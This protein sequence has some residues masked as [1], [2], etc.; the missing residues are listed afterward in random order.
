MFNRLF[1]PWKRASPTEETQP[2]ASDHPAGGQCDGK[3]YDKWVSDM[4]WQDIETADQSTLQNNSNSEVQSTSEVE[5]TTEMID[6]A[7]YNVQEA[8]S[9]ASEAPV[10]PFASDPGSSSPQPEPMEDVRGDQDPKEGPGVFSTFLQAPRPKTSST[11]KTKNLPSRIHSSGIKKMERTRE[12]ARV[13]LRR[14]IERAEA[15]NK[16]REE[17]AA[18]RLV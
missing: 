13:R 12:P 18:E 3:E 11:T 10:Q 9:L 5:S 7:K 14:E 4:I 2:A 17:K 8:M 1:R 6:A 15:A 16:K